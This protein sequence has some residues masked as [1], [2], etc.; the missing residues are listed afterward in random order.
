MSAA[1]Q[2]RTAKKENDINNNNNVININ[3]MKNILMH[4]RDPKQ[5]QLP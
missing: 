4:H 1:S 3:H 2:S 5:E